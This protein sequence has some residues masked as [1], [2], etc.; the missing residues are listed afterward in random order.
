MCVG[1]VGFWFGWLCFRCWWL[2]WCVLE[3]FIDYYFVVG[4][5]LGL[6]VGL[7][8]WLGGFGLFGLFVGFCRW[9]DLSVCFGCFVD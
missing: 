9:F 7:V 3:H 4:L 1:C 2:V 8:D 6:S 5:L